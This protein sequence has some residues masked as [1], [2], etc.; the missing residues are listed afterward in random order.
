MEEKLCS[1]TNETCELVLD[2]GFVVP[3]DIS[4]NDGCVTQDTAASND[5]FIAPEI[6]SFG[7]SFRSLYIFSLFTFLC[8]IKGLVSCCEALEPDL[9][10]MHK[11]FA[12]ITMQKVRGRNL[13]RNSTSRT[14]SIK[15]SIS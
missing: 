11:C 8:C 12:G 13:W 1:E 5:A 4:K 15:H 6:N 3:K 9:S 2:G 14:T 10:F 7:Q